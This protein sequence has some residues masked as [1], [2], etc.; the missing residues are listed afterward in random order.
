[1]FAAQ[2]NDTICPA[3]RTQL[4]DGRSSTSTTALYP[5]FLEF[6]DF[7]IMEDWSKDIEFGVIANE[8]S[9]AWSVITLADEADLAIPIP[10]PAIDTRNTSYTAS[11]IGIR[12]D[13]T[14][15]ARDLT[16]TATKNCTEAGYPLLPYF[17]TSNSSS[18]GSQQDRPQVKDYMFGIVNG[19]LAGAHSRDLSVLST[20]D[21]T[22]VPPFW[23]V[24]RRAR[25]ISAVYDPKVAHQSDSFGGSR[26]PKRL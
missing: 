23:R 25:K 7:V 21:Q 24:R 14:L 5:C 12:A 11:T 17:E 16:T 6:H 20:A 13:C 19:Q 10:G 26:I 18:V 1:M 22:I 15:G 2:F 9:S 3:E 8:S 4:Q